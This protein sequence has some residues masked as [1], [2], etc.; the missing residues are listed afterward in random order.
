MRTLLF[1]DVTKVLGAAMTTKYN[2][3]QSPLWRLSVDA[4]NKTV[5]LGLHDLN[6]SG[7]LSFFGNSLPDT[8]SVQSNIIW[9]ELVDSMHVFLFNDDRDKIPYIS[10]E[11]VQRDD[12]ID[13]SLV[14]LIAH[15]MLGQAGQV[16][17]MHERLVDLLFEGTSLVYNNREPLAVG[18][19]KNLFYL[20]ANG[21]KDEGI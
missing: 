5:Q 16:P 18:C 17:L 7:T 14:D 2:L 11:I 1:E 20:C 9:T 13:I 19:Y 10:Q 4:F 21:G 3:Y 15:D 8:S 12:A 6:R